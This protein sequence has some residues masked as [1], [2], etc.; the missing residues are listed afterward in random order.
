VEADRKILDLEQRHGRD[1]SVRLPRQS[2]TTRG[3]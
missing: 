2:S 1:Q 3:K